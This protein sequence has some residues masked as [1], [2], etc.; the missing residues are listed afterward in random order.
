MGHRFGHKTSRGGR[1]RKGVQDFSRLSQKVGG[2][3]ATTGG[4]MSAT[5]FG[6]ALGAPIAGIGAIVGGVGGVAGGV[7]RF[8]R[9][10]DAEGRLDATKDIVV[11]G[12][13]ARGGLR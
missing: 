13:G 9:E 10:K 7:E 4:V 12:L 2:A 1:F 5:G 6:A 11:G 3:I 8:T